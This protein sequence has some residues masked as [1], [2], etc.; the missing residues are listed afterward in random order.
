M[1]VQLRAV[2]LLIG[3]SLLAALHTRRGLAQAAL[4]TAALDRLIADQMR[5]HRIPGVAVAITQDDQVLLVKGYG[6]ARAGEAVTLQTQFH[7]ASLSK[8]FTAVAIMQLVEAGDLDLD[9]PVQ[10]YLPDFTL[11]DPAAAAQVTVRHLLNHTSGIADAGFPEMRLP[12]PATLAERVDMIGRARPVAAPGTEFHYSNANYGVLARVVEVVSGQP[13]SDYL[14]THLFAP[15]QMEN[16]VNVITSD[17]VPGRADQLAQGHL[18]AYGIPIA[19][20]EEEGVLGGSGGV[21][22]TAA[23]MANY[24]IL[25]T[26][27]GRFQGE[28]LISP[29][30]ITQMHTPPAGVGS[31]YAMG[32][33][34]TEVDGTPTLQHN[35]ILS[36]FYADMVLLPESGQGLVL[37]YN[38]HSVM[39]ASLGFPSLK[40]GMI[41][42]LEGR[43]PETGGIS[44]GM[45]GISLAAITLVSLALQVRALLRLPR[46]MQSIPSRPIWRQVVG[47]VWAFVPAALVLGM[48][49]I[50]LR[51]SDRAFGYLTLF[52]SMLGVMIWLGLSAVLGATIGIARLVGLAR[53]R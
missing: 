2:F 45:V 26:N 10:A 43:E 28:Q 41:A 25:Y 24:L 12:Q 14:Q 34:A 11:A 30:R 31:D 50:V 3:L 38:I 32:W 44:V 53:R 5:A 48:P 37:L 40:H 35:G 49:A 23:D 19:S 8:S 22:S 36:T 20:P 47:I 16:T 17:E 46:W 39:Q 1:N 4:D 18:L 27:G 21:I 15:L 42:I 13:F 52:R 33:I 51:T 7:I 29:E 9:A 6:T